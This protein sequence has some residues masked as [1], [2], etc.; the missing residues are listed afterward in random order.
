VLREKGFNVNAP[1]RAFGDSQLIINFM[2]GVFKRPKKNTIY[3]SIE[4]TRELTRQWPYAV[5]FRHV[6]RD[7]NIVADDMVRRARDLK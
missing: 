2:L 1:I 6:S 5:A 3:S 7:V 4:R